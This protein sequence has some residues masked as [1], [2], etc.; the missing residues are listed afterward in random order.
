MHDS[1]IDWELAYYRL[2]G[3]N[4]TYNLRYVELGDTQLANCL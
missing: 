2:P 3:T 1:E 4:I